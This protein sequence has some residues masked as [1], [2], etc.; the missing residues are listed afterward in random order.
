MRVDKAERV[1]SSNELRYSSA[2]KIT[3]TSKTMSN[4]VFKDGPDVNNGFMT[5][6]LIYFIFNG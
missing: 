2:R 5:K 4:R 3:D 6:P 1:L